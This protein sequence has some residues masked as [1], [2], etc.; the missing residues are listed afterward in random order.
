MNFTLPEDLLDM[1]AAV[2]DFMLAVVEPR[3]R[4]IEDTNRVPPELMRG[5]AELGL[6][7]LSIP[8][9]YGGVGLGALG[10]CAVYEAMGQGHMG[11]GGVISAHASIGTSGLVRLGTEEQKQRFLPRMASAGKLRAVDHVDVAVDDQSIAMGDMV[12]RA[13]DRLLDPDPPDL[14]HRHDVI[15]GRLGIAAV[16]TGLAQGALDHAVAYARERYGGRRG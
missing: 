16:A 6:F 3:A 9:E 12:E 15:A 4:E 1:Q 13:F 2:R 8:E 10:R 11:F 7:G 5:A 14:A